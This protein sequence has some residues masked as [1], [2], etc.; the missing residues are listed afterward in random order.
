MEIKENNILFFIGAGCSKEAGI[1]ISNEMVKDVENS[2]TTDDDFKKS[3]KIY[4]TISKVLLI[5]PK[6]FLGNLMIPSISKS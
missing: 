3:T 4:T 2:I 1:P 5:T 6:E